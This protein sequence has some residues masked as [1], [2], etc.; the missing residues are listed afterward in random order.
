M[1]PYYVCSTSRRAA[2]GGL[3]CRLHSM[4]STPTI[5]KTKLE[6]SPMDYDIEYEL[7]QFNDIFLWNRWG[8]RK[9]RYLHFYIVF[10]PIVPSLG[11]VTGL[12]IMFVCVCHWTGPYE[13]LKNPGAGGYLVY[14]GDN[15]PHP[16]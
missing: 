7:I 12:L 3:S 9:F 13:G 2:F 11:L 1:R 10:G 14:G 16:G 4:Q 8:V 6:K 15:M 5:K